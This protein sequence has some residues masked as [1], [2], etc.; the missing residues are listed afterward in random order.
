MARITYTNSEPL[1]VE[2][3]GRRY[4]GALI[5]KGAQEIR[6]TVEYKGEEI[7]DGRKWGTDAEEDH[8]MRA[9]AQALLLQMVH[10]DILKS[11]RR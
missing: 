9:I 8:N 2:V 11:Q 5:T 4:F 6:I 1:S 3:D 10:D 7:S